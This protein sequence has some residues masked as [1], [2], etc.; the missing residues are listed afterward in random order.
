MYVIK[1]EKS[2]QVANNL[3][4]KKTAYIASVKEILISGLV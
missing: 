2:T 4:R 1:M 3:R